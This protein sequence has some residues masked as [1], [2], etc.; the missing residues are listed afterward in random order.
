M[1]DGEPRYVHTL[2]RAH[3]K[4][5]ARGSGVWRHIFRFMS[6][7]VVTELSMTHPEGL[8]CISSKEGGAVYGHDIIVTKPKTYI[9]E[10]VKEF[11]RENHITMSSDQVSLV[12]K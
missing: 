1:V 9:R 2:L 11:C 5:W 10:V 3:K 4:T 8:K 6:P 7:L 12:V